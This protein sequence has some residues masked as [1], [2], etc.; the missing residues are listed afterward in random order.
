MYWFDL[1]QKLKH[2]DWN[3]NAFIYLT[4]F[5]CIQIDFIFL[6]KKGSFIFKFT[7][8]L[9]YNNRSVF[10]LKLSTLVSKEQNSYRINKKTTENQESEIKLKFL[11][12]DYV[13]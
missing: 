9:I 10:V 13:S 12:E 7:V 1:N 4:W 3:L 8:I 11:S 2:L 5:I 6:K